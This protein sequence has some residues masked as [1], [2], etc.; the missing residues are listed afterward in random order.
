M[1]YENKSLKSQMKRANRLDA[2]RVLIVGESE[3]ASGSVVLRDMADK[4]QRDLP[5]EGLV[6][7]LI[8]IFSQPDVQ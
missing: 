2:G 8:D 6:A 3:L 7:S 5:V 4:T 1:D